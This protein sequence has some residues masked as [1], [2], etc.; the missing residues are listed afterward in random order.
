MKRMHWTWDELG[1]TPRY[2]IDKVIEVL[3]E[4]SDDI[5]DELEG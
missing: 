4:E 1:N 5:E 2:V 3:Q